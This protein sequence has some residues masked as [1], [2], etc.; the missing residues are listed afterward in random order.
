MP[1]HT[2]KISPSCGESCGVHDYRH[3]VQWSGRTVVEEY[4]PSHKGLSLVRETSWR[5]NSRAGT[6]SKST[7]PR[8]VNR[9]IFLSLDVGRRGPYRHHYCCP[10]PWSPS[11]KDEILLLCPKKS[12][13]RV[14][15]Q[16]FQ[17]L[18][19]GVRWSQTTPECPDEER[20]F[21]F[22]DYYLGLAKAYRDNDG[23][24]YVNYEEEMLVE[25]AFYKKEVAA[26]TEARENEVRV[27]YFLESK[28]MEEVV[29]KR[30]CGGVGGGG[31][32]GTG[33]SSSSAKVGGA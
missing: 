19:E 3:H 1:S 24:V 9:Q 25:A 30:I 17:S 6:R 11:V 20:P 33:G 5:S 8:G 15:L 18:L 7:R 14:F 16:K 29:E 31:A 27:V 10:C 4:V 28:V 23:L 22:F 13:T 12:S 21:Y 2:T 32:S 26:A